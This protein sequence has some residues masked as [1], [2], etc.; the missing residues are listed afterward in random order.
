MN[1]LNLEYFPDNDIQI[2]TNCGICMGNV[3]CVCDINNDI[4][5]KNLLTKSNIN[6]INDLF[7]IDFIK[8]NYDKIS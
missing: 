1:T 3:P 7:S 6:K 2:N 4:D 5:Y 8:F